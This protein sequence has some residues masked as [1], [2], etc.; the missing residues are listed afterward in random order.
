[1]AAK[2]YTGNAKPKTTTSKPS[3]LVNCR[4]LARHGPADRNSGLGDLMLIEIRNET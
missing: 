2:P 4:I 3:C 1:M